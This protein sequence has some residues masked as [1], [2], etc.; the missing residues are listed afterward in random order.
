MSPC[1]HSCHEYTAC[2]SWW[3][4]NFFILVSHISSHV[5]LILY[6]F[7]FRCQVSCSPAELLCQCHVKQWKLHGSVDRQ[8]TARSQVYSDHN[9]TL[10]FSHMVH[11]KSQKHTVHLFKNVFI[12]YVS[13]VS[14]LLM[15]NGLAQLHPQWLSG[16]PER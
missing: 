2:I 16:D 11:V 5:F 8:K 3:C 12:F 10:T 4:Y 7:H 9:V 14:E 1:S 6:I 13:R 15:T